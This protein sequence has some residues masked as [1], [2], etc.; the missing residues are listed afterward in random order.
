MS[1]ID[2]AMSELSPFENAMPAG[3]PEKSVRPRFS[4]IATSPR[5]IETSPPQPL[6][7]AIDASV[8]KLEP[9]S[10]RQSVAQY[11]PEPVS[12][13]PEA[14][15]A[16]EFSIERS[17]AVSRLTPPVEPMPV[18]SPVQERS[19]PQAS[20]NVWSIVAASP[21]AEP[22]ST[23]AP[24][25]SEDS[26]VP[27]QTR[28]DASVRIETGAVVTPT[29]IGTTPTPTASKASE[30]IS[31]TPPQ[32]MPSPQPPIDAS[33]RSETQV[34]QTPTQ[35]GV[36]PPPPLSAALRPRERTASD[37]P[38]RPPLLETPEPQ[39]KTAIEPIVEALAR[40]SETPQ[41]TTPSPQLQEPV[42]LPQT[43]PG[44]SARFE[45][46]VVLEPEDS[47][48]PTIRRVPDPP[49]T[50]VVTMIEPATP[51]MT[52]QSQ[53]TIRPSP[54]QPPRFPAWD[55]RPASAQERPSIHVS[56]GA[57]EV[58]AITPPPLPTPTPARAPTTQGFDDYVLV[59]NY[60]NW[61]N[62]EG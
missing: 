9:D 18:S 1:P 17:D 52:T 36:T 37:T 47:Y 51:L 24:P 62:N 22:L 40:I 57:I 56:I 28:L 3:V 19:E 14:Q 8:P 16:V 25:S 5:R 29:A 60:V 46:Q 59:R 2:A 31:E 58:R 27:L 50:E 7:D 39:A 55:G 12:A 53:P 38:L 20:P 48:T 23:V 49:E 26:V 45:T 35:L 44:N 15:A 34:T 13:L 6:T 4:Q 41:R 42:G 21:V 11:K 33:V 32:T 54:V 30:R 61:N 43:A 10:I